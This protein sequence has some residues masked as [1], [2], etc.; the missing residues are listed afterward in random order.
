[1]AYRKK[2][3]LMMRERGAFSE[4]EEELRGD[5]GRPHHRDYITLKNKVTKHKPENEEELL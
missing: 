4:D 5:E 3:K 1:M 2:Q